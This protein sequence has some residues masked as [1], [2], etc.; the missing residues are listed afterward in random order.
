MLKRFLT[1]MLTLALCIVPALG[2]DAADA[3]MTITIS[4]EYADSLASNYVDPLR[5]YLENRFDISFLPLQIDTADASY[6]YRLRAAA[7]E[8]PDVM[9]YDAQW[10]FLYFIQA[11]ALRALPDILSAYPNLR[12][13][14]TYPYA[15][16]LQYNGLIWGIPRS[17]YA[18]EQRLPGYCVLVRREW[19][20]K[21]GMDEPSTV[22]EW[23]ALLRAIRELDDEVIPLTSQSPWAMF[24]FTY[25]YAP[26]SNTWIWEPSMSSYVPGFYTQNYCDRISALRTLWDD[27]LLDPDFMD[28]HCG[29][30]TG[31]DRFLLGQAACI[32]Y[33][34]SIHAV[35]AELLHRWSQINPDQPIEDQVTAVFLPCDS[36]GQYSESHDL[37]MSAIYFSA[38]VSDEK[39][40][41]IL[42]LLDYLCSSEGL[43]LRR[44][45]MEG[46]E[47]VLVDGE[48]VSLLKEGATLY[49][50]YPSYSLLRVLPNLDE[51]FIRSDAFLPPFASQLSEKCGQWEEL[52][53]RQ[54]RH[55]TSMKA[56]TILTG[57]GTYF[58]PNLT[59]ISFRMLTAPEGV[60]ECFESV[61]EGFREQGI[62]QF[63][64][65]VMV[66][67]K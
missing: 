67:L 4:G 38:N 13:Y 32:V 29:R 56:N 61:R 36:E 54:Q 5:E 22:E 58:N 7:N 31:V 46:A 63:I 65:K 1:A 47:Y 24:N 17:L 27:G 42:S 57:S 53:M 48:P 45:G 60:D 14:I 39:L 3:P 9:L 49:D 50:R 37:N 19:L 6:F 18:E 55:W 12:Q 34:T 30:A 35:R 41:R 25:F 43:M 21:T 52:C 23:H 66:N 51:A 15:Q 26:F 16:N 40:D 2:D 8:F 10:D 62:E 33:P 11:N 28:V 64:F 44:W 20:E 59:E